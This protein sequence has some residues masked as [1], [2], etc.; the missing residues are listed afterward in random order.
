MPASLID[1]ESLLAVDVGTVTTQA[2]LFDVVEGIYRF[3]AAGQAPTTAAAP[4]RDLREGVR[5]AIESLQT[6][7]GR[8]FLGPDH[9]IIIPVQDGAGVGS[10]AATIS[11]GPAVKTALVGLLDD[12]SME[13]LQRLARSTY[14][15]IIEIIGLNNSTASCASVPTWC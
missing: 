7:T 14:T 4:F 10:F 8:T 3:V 11:A 6:I 13:S 9:Q 15:R 1:A 5:Q 2:T 12:V